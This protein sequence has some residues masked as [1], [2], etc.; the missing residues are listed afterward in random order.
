M[1]EST[2]RVDYIDT[3]AMGVAHHASYF[4]WLERARVEMLRSIGLSYAQMESE[5]Y[6]LPLRGA[7]IRYR[8]PLRFDDQAQIKLTVGETSRSQVNLHYQ[9]DC[10][11]ELVCTAQTDHVLCRRQ[12]DGSFSPVR[13]PDDWRKQ[14]DR[15]NEKKK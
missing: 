6:I 8:K 1:F 11:D 9:I 12:E 15:L 7:Q 2:L 5:G 14:W 13:I 10:G 3:D 4:R